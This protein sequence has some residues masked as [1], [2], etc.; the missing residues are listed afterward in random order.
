MIATQFEPNRA[1]GMPEARSYR[2]RRRT[3]FYRGGDL[4]APSATEFRPVLIRSA[5]LG[6]RALHLHRTTDRLY[7]TVELDQ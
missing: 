5:V 7:D 1:G 3:V 2:R 4:S 6:F